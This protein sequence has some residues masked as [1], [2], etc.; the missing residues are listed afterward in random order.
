MY[1]FNALLAM[2]Y[3]LQGKQSKRAEADNTTHVCVISSASALKALALCDINPK[4]TFAVP[5]EQ[6]Q[7]LSP[8]IL[9]DSLNPP[10]P[11]TDRTDKPSILHR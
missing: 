5:A 11:A 10:V 7:I 1:G 6:E 8:F 9:G 2:G 4:F 3:H